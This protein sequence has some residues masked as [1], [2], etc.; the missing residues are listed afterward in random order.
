MANLADPFGNG[1]CL[2]ELEGRGYDKLV[3]PEG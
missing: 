3:A 1:F 2:L